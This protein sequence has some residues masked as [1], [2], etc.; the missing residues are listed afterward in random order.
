MSSSAD[1]LTRNT[2][3]VKMKLWSALRLLRSP[4][5]KKVQVQL[6]QPQVSCHMI[7]ANGVSPDPSKVEAILNMAPSTTFTELSRFMTMMNQVG[8][9][10]SHI[11]KLSQ[12]LRKLLTKNLHLGTQPSQ[13]IPQHQRSSNPTTFSPG[14]TLVLR[15]RYQQ[16][17]LPMALVLYCC[18]TIMTGSGHQ[19]HMPQKQKHCLSR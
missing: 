13:S 19:L 7:S 1:V 12:S 9:F 4:G 18:T 5:V 17:L 8:N 6:H 15:P 2:T 16:M 11:I 3:S 10:M 14:T